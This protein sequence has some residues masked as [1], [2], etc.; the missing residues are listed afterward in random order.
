[1]SGMVQHASGIDYLI[2]VD[3]GGSGTRAVAARRAGGAIVGAGKAGPSALGQGIDQA[4]CH[5]EQAIRGAFA[6]GSV[7]VP[8]RSRCV[9]AVGLSGVS[10]GPWR[11]AFLAADPGYA[12]LV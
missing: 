9:L 8:D 10:H 4:W 1:Q 12:R 5:V 6:A 7:A 11:D 2:G 3:G